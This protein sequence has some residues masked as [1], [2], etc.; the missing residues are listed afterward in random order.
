M[1]TDVAPVGA[2]I[3]TCSVGDASVAALD[4]QAVMKRMIERSKGKGFLWF[5]MG[6]IVTK[7][8]NASL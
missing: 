2:V 5:G 1:G 3:N 6:A 8:S 4:E 7:N